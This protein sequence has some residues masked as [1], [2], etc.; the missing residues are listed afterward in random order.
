MLE[1]LVDTMAEQMD[2]S[3]QALRL[4]RH[5]DG[6]ISFSMVDVLG[7]SLCIN[8]TVNRALHQRCKDSELRLLEH[9]A[10]RYQAVHQSCELLGYALSGA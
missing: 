6:S 8:D 3:G 10:C 4:K 9:F 7:G 1:F 5:S 2:S